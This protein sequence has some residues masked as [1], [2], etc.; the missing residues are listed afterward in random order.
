MAR[1]VYILTT[2]TMPFQR[3]NFSTNGKGVVGRLAKAM[4]GRFPKVEF[5]VRD[6]CRCDA[7][8]MT[9]DTLWDIGLAVNKA[10]QDGATGVV[11]THN[12][13]TLEETA[14]FLDLIGEFPATEIFQVNAFEQK[15]KKTQ[16]KNVQENHSENKMQ[17]KEHIEDEYS[18]F[19]GLAY[20]SAKISAGISMESSFGRAK[21]R[22]SGTGSKAANGPTIITASVLNSDLT[23]VQR[24]DD[25]VSSCEVGLTSDSVNYGVLAVVNGEIHLAREIVKVNSWGFDAFKSPFCGPVGFVNSHGVNF[26]AKPVTRTH[27]EYTALVPPVDL[28]TTAIG[29]GDRSIKSLINVSCRGLIVESLGYGNLP[30]NMQRDLQAA[31]EAKIPVVV[32][33]RCLSG[34]VPSP[35]TVNE[36][37][38]VT[39]DLH[40]SKARIKLML[41]LSV[42]NDPEEIA[43]IFARY[44]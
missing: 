36:L 1:R 44:P 39:T 13:D 15:S 10:F 22:I 12:A 33:S 31:L 7:G 37:G 17:S 42:T 11:V 3:E 5:V 27:T 35:G 18:K 41:A 24:F 38:F 14:Y 26:V 2:G 20:P 34:G 25:L 16:E 40:S 8:E 29:S 19:V 4:R 21:G 6:I 30:N 43:R 28:V 32:T 9:T 23:D